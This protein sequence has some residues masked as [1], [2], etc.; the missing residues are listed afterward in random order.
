MTRFV[1]KAAVQGVLGWVI[2]IGLF[3]AAYFVEGYVAKRKRR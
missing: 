1:C 3:E 2:L